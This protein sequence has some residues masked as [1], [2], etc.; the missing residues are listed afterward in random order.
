MQ[1]LVNELVNSLTKYSLNQLTGRSDWPWNFRRHRV[2]VT[3]TDTVDGLKM[4]IG[5]QRS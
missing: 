5:V 3:I 4:S 2:E 1:A